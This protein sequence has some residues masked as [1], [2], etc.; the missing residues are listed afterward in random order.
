MVRGVV[1]ILRKTRPYAIRK[2]LLVPQSVTGSERL[3]ERQCENSEYV[4]STNLKHLQ[5]V[6]G[7]VRKFFHKLQP[8]AVSHPSCKIK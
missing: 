7:T 5:K 4:R 3:M 1:K 8:D 2:L 6:R